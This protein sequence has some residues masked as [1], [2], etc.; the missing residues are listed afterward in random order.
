ML[1]SSDVTGPGLRILIGS[2]GS[3]NGRRASEDPPAGGAA[4]AGQTNRP[5]SLIRFIVSV[6]M[7]IVVLL[8]FAL[9]GG[10]AFI[11]RMVKSAI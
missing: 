5:R 1:C 4:L 7:C 9:L 2:K 10:P 3:R 8:A 6:A 11:G